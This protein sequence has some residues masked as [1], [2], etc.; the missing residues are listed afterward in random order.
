M[1]AGPHA[2]PVAELVKNLTARTKEHPEDAWGFYYLGRAHY[3]AYHLKKVEIPAQIDWHGGRD[4]KPSKIDLVPVDP[5]FGRGVLAKEGMKEDEQRVHVIEGIKA[6]SRAIEIDPS[7]AE[8][9]LCLASLLEESQPFAGQLDVLPGVSDPSTAKGDWP[10]LDA[11]LQQVAQKLPAEDAVKSARGYLEVTQPELFDL[12]GR[13]RKGM[14]LAVYSLRNDPSNDVKEAARKLLREDWMEFAVDEY[15][16]AFCLGLATEAKLSELPLT[17][18]PALEKFACYEAGKAFLRLSKDRAD[19]KDEKVRIATVEAGVK[20]FEKV[21]PCNAITPIIIP[22]HETSSVSDLLAPS[23]RTGFDLDGTGR[24]TQ[25]SWVKPETGILVWD[26][27][28]SG[29]ITSGRQLFGSVSWWMFFRNGYE[30]LDALDDNRDGQLSGPELEGLAVWFD[31]NGNGVCDPGEVIPIDQLGIAAI[32]CRA[33]TMDGESPANPQGLR[34]TDGR[35]LPTYD[36]I[37]HPAADHRKSVI[38]PSL[39]SLAAL[40][41]LSTFGALSARRR[42]RTAPQEKST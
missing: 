26:P 38:L 7:K 20:A 32:S 13:A 11:S 40:A 37:A 29:T 23:T 28:H 15:F 8:F 6:L 10:D 3:L 22:M 27:D 41:G 4:T 36:W 30:A 25:W 5:P 33:T 24:H 19:R 9:H 12:N 31:R 17:M 42:H 18:G 14:A 39:A 1:F 16:R 34:M 21:P 35:V 2:A